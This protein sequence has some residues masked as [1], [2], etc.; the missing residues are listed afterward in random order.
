MEQASSGAGRV[1]PAFGRLKSSAL[2]CSQNSRGR[3]PHSWSRLCCGWTAGPCAGHVASV[4]TSRLGS[5]AAAGGAAVGVRIL[6]EAWEGVRAW[7]P[8]VACP[9]PG[10]DEVPE[11]VTGLSARRGCRVTAS[12]GATHPGRPPWPCT[13]DTPS[14][15]LG[16]GP[17]SSPLRPPCLHQSGQRHPKA[18]LPRF[19]IRHRERRGGSRRQ[20]VNEA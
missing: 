9:K 13:S 10:L 17:P 11:W 5:R 20:S 15:G 16:P 6:W 1:P 8:W 19:R 2:R 18:H 4:G 7:V 3:S 14:L 12:S